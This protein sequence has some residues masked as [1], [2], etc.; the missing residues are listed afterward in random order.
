MSLAP[1]VPS[2]PRLPLAKPGQAWHDPKLL[3]AGFAIGIAM[4]AAV[5]AAAYR[6]LG[7]F[8]ARVAAVERTQQIFIAAQDV[9]TLLKDGVIAQRGFVITGE[10]RYL[11]PYDTALLGREERM[12]ALKDLLGPDSHE[13][14]ARVGELEVLI[15][16]VL[17]HIG[18]SVELRLQG[19]D[20]RSREQVVLID[21]GKRSLDRA[22]AV[23]KDMRTTVNDELM[24]RLHETE[25]SGSRTKMLLLVTDTIAISVLLAA[26]GLLRRQ[27]IERERADTALQ[28]ANEE[29]EQRI[30]ERTRQ[31]ER[32]NEDMNVKVTEIADLNMALERRVEERT[33][34]LAQANQGLESFAYSVSHD[35]RTPLR[36]IVGFTRTLEKEYGAALDDEGRRLIGIVLQSGR[37]MDRLIEDLLSFARLRRLVVAAELLDM[38]ALANEA[39]RDIESTSDG[40]ARIRMGELPAVMADRSL[41]WEVWSNL[42]SNAFKFSG[43]H[44]QPVIEISGRLEAD[45]CIYQV[46]DNGVGFNM[47]YYDRLF[48][49]FERLHDAEAFPGSGVGLAIVRS[50]LAKHQGKVWAESE[51]GQGAS[52]YFSLPRM[53]AR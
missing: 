15:A 2:A 49:V 33:A 17:G 41:M 8:E 46:R 18:K 28:Q 29:L 37:R 38:R 10:A 31:L 47:K 22:R 16:E 51:I 34:E 39:L 25:Q 42:L 30:F 27:L 32:A 13:Q 44:A 43:Q 36:A 40:R 12:N 52:F 7:E 35:L 53:G 11:E 9:L 24:D 48:G 4:L 45:T 3:L 26:F 23:V 14:R 6:G 5:G 19:A 21:A 50:A 20:A 1:R